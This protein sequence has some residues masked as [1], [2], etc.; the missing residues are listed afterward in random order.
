MAGKPKQTERTRHL[1]PCSF[2]LTLSRA[3]EQACDQAR[4]QE[5][6]VEQALAGCDTEKLLRTLVARDVPTAKEVARDALLSR[7]DFWNWCM[8]LTGKPWSEARARR[9]MRE[10]V[11]IWQHINTQGAWVP[12]TQDDLLALWAQA[13]KGEFPLYRECEAP[14]FRV[15]GVPFAHGPNPFEPAP[16]PSGQ[17]T[18]P[19]EEIPAQVDVLLELIADNTLPLEA[20]AAAAHFALGAIHPFRDGNGHCARMLMCAMLAPVYSLATLLALDATIQKSR[21][22]ITK[23]FKSIVGEHQDAEDMCAFLLKLLL[24]AQMLVIEAE[25]CLDV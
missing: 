10:R 19:P 8:S 25:A 9:D 4:T 18:T 13:T 3:I 21:T 23:L 2:V 16:L 24:D 15:K 5:S 20:R 17:Q 1:L 22:E 11:R 14:Q 7:E 6:K 12:R